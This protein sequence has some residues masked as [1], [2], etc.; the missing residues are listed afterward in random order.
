M[1]GPTFDPTA[2]DLPH[3]GWYP[4][5][6]GSGGQRWWDGHAWTSQVRLDA[7]FDDP[8]PHPWTEGAATDDRVPDHGP[9]S[10]LPLAASGRNRLVLL[11]VGALLVVG[12]LVAVAVGLANSSGSGW[13]TGDT[14]SDGGGPFGEVLP[15]VAVPAPLDR[16]DVA[17]RTTAAGCVT[18]VDGEP[19]EDRNHLDPAAAPP[20]AVLYPDRP[21]HSGPHFGSLLPVPEGVSPVPIDERAVLHNMEHGSVVVWFDAD[22]SDADGRADLA[23]WR[24]DR[25]ALGFTSGASGAVFASPMPILGDPPAIALRAWGVAVDCERFDPVVADAFLVEHWG[26]H[27]DAPEAHLSPFPQGSLRWAD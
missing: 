13:T 12:L 16:E 20:A 9:G 2:R 14:T 11:L 19:L 10:G 18:V 7:L 27:G 4:D 8:P 15:G 25:D 3:P 24:R 21:A 17:A 6:A 1:S 5:P 23:R 26:S 22:R